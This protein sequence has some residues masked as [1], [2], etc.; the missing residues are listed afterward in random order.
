MGGIVGGILFFL[1]G[2]L[3][4]GMLLMDFM[5]N[6]TGAAGNVS[7]SEPD[8]YIGHR[9]PGDVIPAGVYIRKGNVNSMVGIHYRRCT[10]FTD[11]GRV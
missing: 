4:Y 5:N 11:V 6:H 7:R 9:Q 1:L 8:F 3:I 10:W 2:W